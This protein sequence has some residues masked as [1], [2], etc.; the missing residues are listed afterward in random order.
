L[1]WVFSSVLWKLKEDGRCHTTRGSPIVGRDKR[2]RTDPKTLIF[3]KRVNPS[4][5]RDVR[6]S[7]DIRRGRFYE[8]E[9]GE[10][11]GRRVDRH[12]TGG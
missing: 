3:K 11:D 6:E 10:T 4:G 1:I 5:R 12:V 7:H 2:W 8:T 9:G